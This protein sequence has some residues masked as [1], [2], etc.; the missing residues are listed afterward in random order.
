MR[1]KWKNRAA[2]ANRPQVALPATATC[3]PGKPPHMSRV[4]DLLGRLRTNQRQTRRRRVAP[5]ALTRRRGGQLAAG[6]WL[7]GEARA[8]ARG[9]L[10][11][12]RCANGCLPR[13]RC[14]FVR[15]WGVAWYCSDDFSY[16]VFSLSSSSGLQTMQMICPFR[17]SRRARHNGVVHI[18][19]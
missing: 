10:G 5:R 8:R 1:R 13:G 3:Q 11:L 12:R 19:I 18:G 7:G 2:R 16:P 4:S 6:T 14:W 15:L 17:S 9:D